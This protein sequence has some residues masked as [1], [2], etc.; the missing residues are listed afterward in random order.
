MIEFVSL[1]RQFDLYSS[2]YEEAA[3]RTLRSGWYIMGKELETFETQFAQYLGV[4]FITAG[5][6]LKNASKAF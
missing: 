4:R 5:S 3:L 2:E 6:I 1:K